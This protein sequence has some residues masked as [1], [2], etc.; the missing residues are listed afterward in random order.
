MHIIS[1]KNMTA[2]FLTLTRSALNHRMQIAK[3]GY[4]KVA[5]NGGGQVD[6]QRSKVSFVG[7]MRY[8]LP[9][10]ALFLQTAAIKCSGTTKHTEGRSNAGS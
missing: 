6:C 9:T 4:I 3:K 2:T 1:K 7:G 10:T 8:V 5:Y